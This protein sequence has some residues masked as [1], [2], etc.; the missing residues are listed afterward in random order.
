MST[1]IGVTSYR[2]V[3][4]REAWKQ[5]S[6]LLP[7]NYVRRIHDAGGRALLIPPIGGDAIE[8]LTRLDGLVVSGGRDIAPS[9]YHAAAHPLTG[10][11]QPA[12]DA[13]EMD[14]I[15]AALTLGLPLLGVCRG[16]QL[17]NVCQGGTLDQHLPDRLGHDGHRGAPGEFS[18]HGVHIKPRSQIATALG[19]SYA[20]V[21]SH[22]HQGIDRLGRELNAVAWAVGDNTVEAI[23]GVDDR[24]QVGVLWHPEEQ[25]LPDLFHALVLAAAGTRMTRAAS[26]RFGMA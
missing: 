16:M 15:Q 12:R 1:L 17:L 9:Q 23:E 14:L 18:T 26:V 6:A 3:I 7:W 25:Q 11:T 21:R 5:D 24:F 13:A 20:T 8:L 10:E 22:H 2:E 4:E 19:K